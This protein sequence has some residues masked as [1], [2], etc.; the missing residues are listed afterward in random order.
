MNFLVFRL[1]LVLSTRPFRVHVNSLSH[2]QSF[3]ERGF[4][5]NKAMSDTNM[6]EEGPVNQRLVY[7]VLER[8]EKEV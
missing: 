4:N 8:S 2:G 3:T 5:I 7:D 6:K 1:R